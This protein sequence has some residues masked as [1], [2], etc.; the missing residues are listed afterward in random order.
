MNK[1]ITICPEHAFCAQ[2][3]AHENRFY[4]KQEQ[5][6]EDLVWAIY[7]PDGERMAQAFSREVALAIVRQ[8]DLTAAQVH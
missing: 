4:I 7:S 2:E 5:Q 6:N 1:K 3:V 8:N